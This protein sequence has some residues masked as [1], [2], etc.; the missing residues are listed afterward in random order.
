MLYA[1][2]I[3]GHGGGTGFADM[4]SAYEAMAP[5]E[6]RHLE[7]LRAIHNLDFSRN[8]RHGSDPMTEAQR[9]AV[10]PV[11]HPVVRIHPETGR[12]AIYLGDHAETIV[13]MDYDEG[14]ASST[15]STSASSRSAVPIVTIGG[16]AT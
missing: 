7:A 2:M 1:E 8:R 15:I 14:A 4:Y 16:R 5:D 12:K 13:G 10:P 11:E 6:Q 3:P 9:S